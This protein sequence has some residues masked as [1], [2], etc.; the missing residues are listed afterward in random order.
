LT[1]LVCGK[2]ESRADFVKSEDGSEHRRNGDVHVRDLEPSDVSPAVYRVGL[3]LGA[4]DDYTALAVVEV[5]NVEHSGEARYVVRHLERWRQPYPEIIPK[6]IDV[7]GRLPAER[8]QLLVDATGVGLPI[9]QMLRLADLRLVGITIT[10]GDQ[11]GHNSVG[12]TV[13][14]A[15]LVGALQVVLQTKRLKVA[16][17]LSAGRTLASELQAFTRRQNPV[18]GRNQFAVWRDGEHDDLV[19]A[20]SMAVWHG[21]HRSVVHFY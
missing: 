17:G 6:V 16:P 20:V 9:V 19:L 5:A 11:T 13:P 3:D 10:A 12:I 8:C 15:S 2:T 21:E 4:V 7:M 1:W 14:K 18:T